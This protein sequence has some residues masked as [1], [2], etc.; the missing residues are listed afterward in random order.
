MPL[1][2]CLSLY[3]TGTE[4]HDLCPVL[5]LASFLT[6][7]FF[8]KLLE[9]SSPLLHLTHSVMGVRVVYIHW[10]F[11]FLH[12]RKVVCIFH[13]LHGFVSLE[14]R[15]SSKNIKRIYMANYNTTFKSLGHSHVSLI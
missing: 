4:I 9:I 11:K 13:L 12:L 10:C 7:N 1:S 2:F 14:V 8:Y 6:S 5:L 3:H 15:S